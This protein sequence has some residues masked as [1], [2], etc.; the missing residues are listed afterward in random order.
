MKYSEHYQNNLYVYVCTHTHRCSDISMPVIGNYNNY[1][2][3]KATMKHQH[4]GRSN[5]SCSSNL[6]NPWR[7][8]RSGVSMSNVSNSFMSHIEPWRKNNKIRDC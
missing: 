3:I 6:F 7:T 2:Q 8:A 1:Q 4:F 5:Q